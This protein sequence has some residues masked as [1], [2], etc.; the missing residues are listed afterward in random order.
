MEVCSPIF[1]VL[2]EREGRWG[3]VQSSNIGLKWSVV[4]QLLMNCWCGVALWIL[5][6]KELKRWHAWRMGDLRCASVWQMGW[7]RRLSGARVLVEFVLKEQRRS[8][9]CGGAVPAKS[10]SP[11]AAS[12]RARLEEFHCDSTRKFRVGLRAQANLSA[13]TSEPVDKALNGVYSILFRAKASGG[14]SK[15]REARDAQF[16][17]KITRFALIGVG[18]A[19]P[20]CDPASV[21]HLRY[22]S[23]SR[24]FNE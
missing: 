1:C 10:L 11:S 15:A 4:R 17:Q 24:H 21:P 16:L 23:V 9:R 18:P 2:V 5:G 7:R 14:H 22:L 3:Y 19:R 20:D 12:C 6:G 8:R 13:Q